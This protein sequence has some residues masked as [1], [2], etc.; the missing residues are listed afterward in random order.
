MSAYNSHESEQLIALVWTRHNA[1]SL[2]ASSCSLAS[3]P[4]PWILLIQSY[5]FFYNETASLSVCFMSYA[6][7]GAKLGSPNSFCIQKQALSLQLQEATAH[8][9]AHCSA[10]T[11]FFCSWNPTQV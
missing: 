6:K 10:A 2:Q 8:V 1:C 4:Q 7:K 5:F 3:A 11:F 9:I